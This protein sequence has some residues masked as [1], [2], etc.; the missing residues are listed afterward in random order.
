MKMNPEVK[1]QW[2]A[3]L[4]SG[5]YEQGRD[6]L[7]LEGKYCCLGVLCDLA[8]KSGQD[9]RVKMETLAN[10]IRYDGET[11]IAPASVVNWAG[12][13][14][15][16]PA[17]RMTAREAFPEKYGSDPGAGDFQLSLAELNDGGKTFSEIADII[18]EE[19]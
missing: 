19:F 3:A 1:A 5:E 16:N 9:V 8:V 15:G 11:D 18:E 6:A 10:Q 7:T 17:V 13:D 12:L 2:V 4:R 14:S